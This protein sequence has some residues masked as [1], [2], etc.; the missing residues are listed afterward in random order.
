MAQANDKYLQIISNIK[1]GELKPVYLL[2]GDESYYIDSITDVIIENALDD[3]E[4]DFNQTILYGLDAEISSL[5]NTA[6]RYPMMSSRQLVVLK[7]AQMFDDI[8]DIIL[9]VEH[10]QPSTVFVINYK[11]GVLKNKKLITAIEKIGAVYEFKK[12]YENQVPKFITDYLQNYSLKIEPKA[13]AMLSDY[14]GNDLSRIAGELDKLR[15]VIGGSKEITAHLV[16]DN[17]GISKDYNNFEFL[18][19]LVRKDV[20]KVNKIINY[21]ESNPKNN[22]I[23]PIIRMMFNFFS[24]L[25]LMY[26]APDKSDAGLLKELN[27]KTTFQLKEYNTAKNNYNVF[28]CVD[29]I[30]L[31][32]EYD[33]KSKGVGVSTSTTDA[34]LLRELSYKIMH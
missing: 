8:D 21:F 13:V 23:I 33:A 4:R 18:A 22:S 9:Y 34:S 19:A 3:S 30:A 2:M 31:L 7:E 29:I 6:K 1:K 32:R 25:L 28:K 16:E 14:I 26:Y 5:I 20:Y 15:I 10:Y 11:G 12:L 24:N 17:I 27:L